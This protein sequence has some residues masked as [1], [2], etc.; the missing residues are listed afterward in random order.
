MDIDKEMT[1]LV[2]LYKNAEK[3]AE[4]RSQEKAEFLANEQLAIEKATESI[5]NSLHSISLLA[6]AYQSNGTIWFRGDGEPYYCGHFGVRPDGKLVEV[7]KIQ[8]APVVLGGTSII[9][10]SLLISI[11]NVSVIIFSL[12]VL[13]IVLYSLR[14]GSFE[15]KFNAIRRAKRFDG[16]IRG[17]ADFLERCSIRLQYR[18][19][20]GAPMDEGAHLWMDD[21][22]ERTILNFEKKRLGIQ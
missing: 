8:E 22:D 6:K 1:N 15:R 7:V 21:D 17:M 2:S 20:F 11:N 5:P 14:K 3:I 4:K 18:I 10:L 9:F 16:G 12:I 19:E 13:G